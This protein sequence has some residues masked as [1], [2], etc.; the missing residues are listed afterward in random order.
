MQPARSWR[1]FAAP[2]VVSGGLAQE[3]PWPNGQGVGPLIRRLGVRVPQGVLQALAA[4]S[5]VKSW[6]PGK[7]SWLSHLVGKT[8]FQISKLPGLSGLP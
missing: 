7:L 3:P 2:I 6:Q 5:S 1:N 4:T 8:S